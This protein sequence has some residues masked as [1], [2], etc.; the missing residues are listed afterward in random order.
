MDKEYYLRTIEKIKR[1]IYD[2]EV[3]QINFS[4]RFE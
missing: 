2:G 4:Q 1:Y 3:Y